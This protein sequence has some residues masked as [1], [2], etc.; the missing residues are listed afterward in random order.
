MRLEWA[1][2]YANKLLEDQLCSLSIWMAMKNLGFEWCLENEVG[3]T[4]V[5][6]F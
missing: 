5:V 1:R 6:G 4:D 3:M 2:I